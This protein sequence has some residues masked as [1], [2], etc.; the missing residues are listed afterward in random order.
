MALKIV[1]KAIEDD[2]KIRHK[3]CKIGQDILNAVSNRQKLTQKH[4]GLWIA[5]HQAMWFEA[6]LD[7]F[8]AASN[9]IGINMISWI[10]ISIEEVILDKFAKNDNVYI[11]DNT[12]LKWMVHCSCDNI[13]AFK[14]TLNGKNTFHFTQMRSCATKRWSKREAGCEI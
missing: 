14:V 6:L 10:N 13:N 2:P 1:N 11:P 5:L 9:T 4:I 7:I 8:H 12:A 3:P